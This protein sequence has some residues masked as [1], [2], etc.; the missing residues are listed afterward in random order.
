MA[1]KAYIGVDNVARK[2]KR[3]YV[4][5]DNIARRIR[6]AYIG[7]GGVARPCWS[8]GEVE[9]YGTFSYSPN[10]A[11]YELAATTIGDYALFAGGR[12][13]HDNP[14]SYVGG[15]VAYNKSLTQVSASSLSAARYA[16]AAT[17]IGN[18]ALF[19]GGSGGGGKTT[20]DAYDKSL[21]RTTP[22]ILGEARAYLTATTVSGSYA[23]FAGGVSTSYSLTV[24]AYNTSLTRSTPTSLS[25][26]RSNLAATNVGGYALFAGGCS[27]GYSNVLNTIDAYDAS[28]TRTSPITLSS[29]RTHLAAT[30]VGDY[31][32]FA[33]GSSGDRLNNT[34]HGTSVVN[35]YNTSLTSVDAP[36]LSL[37]RYSFSA[38]T[39]DECAIFGPGCRCTFTNWYGTTTSYD[40]Y[41]KYLTKNAKNITSDARFSYAASVIGNYA[42]FFGGCAF[43]YP[44][45]A[46]EVTN[47]RIETIL[48][49]FTVLTN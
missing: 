24:D 20:V 19:G 5:V 36:Y 13:E 33:G 12:S 35:A 14:S 3:G 40:T 44:S 28:L 9:V 42:I 6:K 18:Y 39:L 1:K 31:A 38:V 49:T 25:K 7:V 21:T 34:D 4:G 37:T 17:T 43:S 11:V 8:S 22:A 48:Q 15:V 16:L 46:D 45:N 41:D 32:L 10:V 2:V 30:T 26:S 29:A 23:L 27:G 47:D